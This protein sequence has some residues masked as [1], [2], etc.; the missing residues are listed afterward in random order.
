Y[1][2]GNKMRVEMSQVDAYK[3]KTKKRTI[4]E[5]LGEE[6][7]IEVHQSKSAAPIVW[8]KPQKPNE[9]VICGQDH[10]LDILSN[11]LQRHPQG[12]KTLRSYVG[13]YN[14]L[15][16][17]YQDMVQVATTHLWDGKTGE[18]NLPYIEKMLPGIP[19]TVIHIADR[20]MGYYVVN[21]NPKN[22]T[23]WEDLK[24]RD[25]SIINREKGSGT[26][27]LLDERLK[28]MKLLSSNLKGYDREC[29]SH[30]AMASAVSRGSADF[31]LGIEKYGMT[32]KRIDFV[33]LQ[34]EKYDLVIKTENLRNPAYQA[35]IE[36][37]RSEEFRLEL[38]GLGGYDLE[39]IGETVI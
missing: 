16:M 21:G 35:I 14:G 11:Y 28:K 9:I 2:I 36:V 4:S 20:M 15:Y 31:A 6:E 39:G 8:E 13:S 24:R 10:T 12:T 18:Y 33:P 7:A 29:S 26:R 3:N 38:E 37:I 22:I 34:K 1:K 30:L 17:L 5:S 32:V 19:V 25:I 23:S 27:I